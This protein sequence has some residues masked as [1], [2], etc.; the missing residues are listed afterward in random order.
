LRLHRGRIRLPLIEVGQAFTGCPTTRFPSLDGRGS[1]GGWSAKNLILYQ[2]DH[3]HPNPPPSRGRAF[4]GIAW[5]YWTDCLCPSRSQRDRHRGRPHVRLFRFARW[6]R[7]PRQNTA[8]L[9]ERDVLTSNQLR[10]IKEM[11]G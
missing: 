10:N 11:T 9:A 8:G 7:Y 3:P 6:L 2:I 5:G 1:R 4:G